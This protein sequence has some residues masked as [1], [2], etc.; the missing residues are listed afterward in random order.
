MEKTQK[1]IEELL[2]KYPDKKPSEILKMVKDS[3]YSVQKV[4]AI[5]KQMTQK[6]EEPR[7]E[8]S[9]KKASPVKEEVSTTLIKAKPE[10]KK[11]RVTG[12]GS[13]GEVPSHD[14]AG[15]PNFISI[16]GSDNLYYIPDIH[17]LLHSHVSILDTRDPSE[18]NEKSIKKIPFESSSAKNYF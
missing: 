9:S 12:N 3:S 16:M 14:E 2:R 17:K 8:K 15:N 18:I 10:P 6:K 1:K 7:K 4:T 11:V 13:R 5:R